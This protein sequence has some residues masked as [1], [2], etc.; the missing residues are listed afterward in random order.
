MS[1][2]PPMLKNNTAFNRRQTTRGR[3]TDAHFIVPVTLTLTWRLWT[4]LT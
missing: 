1:E 2:T 4:N 3:D